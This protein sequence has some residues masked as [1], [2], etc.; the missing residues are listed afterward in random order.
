MARRI[1]SD[2]ARDKRIPS[3]ADQHLDS[4]R[5][6]ARAKKKA[7]AAAKAATSAKIRDLTFRIPRIIFL[8]V[9]LLGWSAG[10]LFVAVMMFTGKGN[11]FLVVWEIF[12]V[13]GWYAGF[14]ALINTIKG[15]PA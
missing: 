6:K 13:F 10:V 1:G 7:K 2:G 15:K 8:L 9:W 12:A 11:L 14:R 4:F 5:A 3:I